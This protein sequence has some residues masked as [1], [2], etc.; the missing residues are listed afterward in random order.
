MMKF[1]GIVQGKLKGGLFRVQCTT[2]I[3]AQLIDIHL[4]N[5]TY[6][7]DQYMVRDIA[8]TQEGPARPKE[9]VFLDS[10]LLTN[11]ILKQII[12][13]ILNY[14]ISCWEY[15]SFDTLYDAAIYQGVISAGSLL[16]V[17]I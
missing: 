4:T 6:T 1:S 12:T 16:T 15:E 2:S 13:G 7:W 5:M 3:T 10:D 14:C 11:E 8:V 9:D 17:S